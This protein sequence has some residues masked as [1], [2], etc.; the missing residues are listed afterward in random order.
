[1]PP[2]YEAEERAA[3]NGPNGR[4][5]FIYGG[6]DGCV[7]TQLAGAAGDV[8]ARG[9][10]SLQIPDAEAVTTRTARHV[11]DLY[12]R[13]SDRRPQHASDDLRL[14]VMVRCW[15][16]ASDPRPSAEVPLAHNDPGYCASPPIA[17]H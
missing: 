9:S 16:V 8:L 12:E 3:R 2:A 10:R 1:V 11:H 15:Y 14:K 4:R 17:C 13:L 5:S 6:D 7:R